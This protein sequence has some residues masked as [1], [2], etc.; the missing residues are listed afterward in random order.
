M[1]YVLGLFFLFTF[2]RVDA[3]EKFTLNGYIKDS[4]SGETLIGASVNLQGAGRG[5]TSNQYGFYSL[6]LPK[7]TY[8]LQLING[9]TVVNR[10]LIIE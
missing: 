10:Q 9:E 1:R 7:G 8:R 6:T 5:V 4:L 3:Q 2:Y